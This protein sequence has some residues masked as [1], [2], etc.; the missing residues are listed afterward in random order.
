MVYG[1]CVVTHEERITN[2]LIIQEML[3]EDALVELVKNR[4]N[5]YQFNKGFDSFVDVQFERKKELRRALEELTGGPDAE[6][7]GRDG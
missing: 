4:R 5:D 7:F 6:T 1:R 3:G 2:A